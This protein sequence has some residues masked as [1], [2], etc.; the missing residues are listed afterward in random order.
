MSINVAKQLKKVN[1]R[2]FKLQELLF[3]MFFYKTYSIPD[4]FI[5]SFE[6]LNDNLQC[7]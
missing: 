5:H 7:K 4:E 1:F 3:H 6:A 2:S